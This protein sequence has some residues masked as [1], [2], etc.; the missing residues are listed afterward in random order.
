MPRRLCTTEIPRRMQGL[1]RDPFRGVPIP[2]FMESILRWNFL[3]LL[4]SQIGIHA[5]M[6]DRCVLC[7]LCWACG[8]TLAK[9]D[10]IG[11]PVAMKSF[12]TRQSLSPPHHAT[13]AVFAARMYPLIDGYLGLA[14]APWP[15][16]IL[17]RY[18]FTA[19]W[20]PKN[21]DWETSH[22]VIDGYTFQLG[23]QARS[24]AFFRDGHEVMTG[25]AIQNDDGVDIGFR[26]RRGGGEKADCERVEETDRGRRQA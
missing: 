18:D 8:K 15:T 4:P 23:K 17:H 24:L 3:P 11:F 1:P 25:K 2:Y 22:H 21:D 12:L 7:H 6:L 9:H 26:K 16:L 5:T 19:A 10:D 20:I 13:C 14:H